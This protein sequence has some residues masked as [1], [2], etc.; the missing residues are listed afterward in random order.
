MGAALEQHELVVLCD[1]L[2]VAHTAVAQDAALAVDRDQGGELERL[3]EVALGLNKARN[4]AAPAEGDVLQRALA[5]LVTYGAVERMVDQQELDDGL[6]RGL[7]AL[8]LRVNDHAVLDG[9]RAAG[10]QLGD[11]L[12]F[13]EA[14]AAC[15]DGLTE[16]GLITEDGDLDVAVLGGV[17]QHRVLGGLY[18]AAV[19]REG[20]GS[21]FWSRHRTHP[22][23]RVRY[24][25]PQ[26]RSGPCAP[27]RPAYALR[28]RL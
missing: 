27:V 3:D 22:G 8:A 24:R 25:R 4:A 14:H 23:Q 9:R 5:A 28:T 7:D 19:D 13:D 2:G 15:A 10:L 26:R 1:L 6:L 11:A 17:D 21:R 12:D 20:D 18:L 16:L